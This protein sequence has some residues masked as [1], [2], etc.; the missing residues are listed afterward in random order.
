MTTSRPVAHSRTEKLATTAS[1]RH[2]IIHLS[3]SP[4]GDVVISLGLDGTVNFWCTRSGEN[5]AKCAH[6]VSRVVALC[7]ART[8]EGE[9]AMGT[10]CRDGV[11]GIWRLTRSWL[12][13]EATLSFEVAYTGWQ[14]VNDACLAFGSQ[15][16]TLAASSSGS[17]KVGLNRKAAYM[18]CYSSVLSGS[19]KWTVNSLHDGT[20]VSHLHF[21]VPTM[22]R[23]RRNEGGRANILLV[24]YGTRGLLLEFDVYSGCITGNTSATVTPKERIVLYHMSEGISLYHSPV[25]GETQY[26]A[27]GKVPV[28]KT[29]RCDALVD[30]CTGDETILFRD[31]E[32]RVYL[33]DCVTG[34]DLCTIQTEGAHDREDAYED[35]IPSLRGQSLSFQAWHPKKRDRVMESKRTAVGRRQSNKA[36]YRAAERVTPSAWTDED[37]HGP[38]D[39][40]TL[41]DYYYQHTVE[42]ILAQLVCLALTLAALAFW[43]VV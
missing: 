31:D 8:L 12:P 9:P 17:V 39:G 36:T 38:P 32:G 27:A 18:T 35:D 3:Q 20:E 5:L 29:G 11:A 37:V 24:F 1:A 10:V 41:Q 22:G 2:K 23:T 7:R 42:T 40:T 4:D 16:G 13:P 28:K 25:P 6:P 43:V 21:P 14:V 19:A 34:Q 33:Y 30:S 26:T 15:C